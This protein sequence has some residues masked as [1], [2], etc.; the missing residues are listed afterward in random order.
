[1]PITQRRLEN[2]I[3]IAR[4]SIKRTSRGHFLVFDP[5]GK[6]IQ[7]YAVRHP[8]REVLDVYV[9]RVRKALSEVPKP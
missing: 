2:E 1:M 8:K 6:Q 5:N 4:C 3:K 9:K 7:T